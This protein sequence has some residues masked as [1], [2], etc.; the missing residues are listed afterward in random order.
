MMQK[1]SRTRWVLIAVTFVWFLVMLLSPAFRTGVHEDYAGGC[2][3]IHDRLEEVR[4]LETH[5]IECFK[6]R[7]RIVHASLYEMIVAPESELEFGR[8]PDTVFFVM[9]VIIIL[10]FPLW[11]TLLFKLVFVCTRLIRKFSQ[12]KAPS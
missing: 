8:N 6:G 3:P 10:F 2:P 4:N 12:Q 9:V 11:I 7:E 5:N 1:Q